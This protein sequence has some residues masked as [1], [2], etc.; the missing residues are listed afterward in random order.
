MGG[1]RARY[2][3]DVIKKQNERARKQEARM[4]TGGRPRGTE[5]D[6]PASLDVSPFQREILENKQVMRT[7]RFRAKVFNSMFGKK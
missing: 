5:S 3:R 7:N 1:L 4:G 6:D 2:E